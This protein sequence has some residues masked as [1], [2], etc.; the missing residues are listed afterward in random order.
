MSTSINQFKAGKETV[1]G[2][3][4]VGLKLNLNVEQ[5]RELSS[6]YRNLKG[7]Q[8]ETE[9]TDD[10]LTPSEER[11]LPFLKIFESFGW[12]HCIWESLQ[13]ERERVSANPVETRCAGKVEL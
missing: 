8:S 7:K 3:G 11:M 10:P 6:L 2:F 9:V 5:C 12:E 4:I 13:D 1:K